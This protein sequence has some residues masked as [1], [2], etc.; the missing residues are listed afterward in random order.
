MDYGL[1]L[2]GNC[3]GT[4]WAGRTH[5]PS[6]RRHAKPRVGYSFRALPA[7]ACRV[8]RQTI[9]TF[10]GKPLSANASAERS[11]DI[12]LLAKRPSNIPLAIFFM[13]ASGM[14]FSASNAASK[15]LIQ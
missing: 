11:A 3:D 7:P 2:T 9:E 13:V 8:I 6:R 15:W 14:V 4:K 10:G 1:T 5:A 12:A